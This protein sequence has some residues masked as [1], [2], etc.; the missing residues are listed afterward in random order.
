MGK[1]YQCSHKRIRNT[2]KP[3]KIVW[4]ACISMTD[5][6]IQSTPGTVNIQ[7]LSKSSTVFPVPMAKTYQL[8][9]GGVRVEVGP[10]W[11][12]VSSWHLTEV[13]ENQLIQA[14]REHYTK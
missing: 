14:Y 4:N 6:T 10:F 2:C 13:A 8:E 1:L 9:D 3:A 7:D 5:G 12:V 11:K